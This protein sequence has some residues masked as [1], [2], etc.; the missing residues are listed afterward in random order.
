MSRWTKGELTIG[1]I[2]QMERKLKN[3]QWN[4]EHAIGEPL[5]FAEDALIRALTL[6]LDILGTMLKG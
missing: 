1:E 3:A 5:S 6:T 2:A 4:L